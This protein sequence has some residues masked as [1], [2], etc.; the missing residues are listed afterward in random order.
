MSQLPTNRTKTN[1]LDEHVADHNEI[2]RIHNIMDAGGD[3]R[4]IQIGVSDPNG[5][6]I[7]TGD[8]KAY[9][10]V[11]AV[12]NAFKLTAVS[13]TVITASSS[14][15][16]NVQIANNTGGYDMLSTALTI[17]ANETDSSTAATPAV[18]DTASAHDTVS[19]ADVLR[20]DID[21]AGTGT[22][23]LIV[24]MTFSPS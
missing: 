3:Q 11:P 5:S 1:T 20:I 4:V 10:R 23:G 9:F 18:I 8:G 14:G 13:A 24:S 2:H 6:A 12:M 21:G 17:D 15:L 22:K 16:P 19:T 7:T